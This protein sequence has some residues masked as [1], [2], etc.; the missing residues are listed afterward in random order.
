MKCLHLLSHCLVLSVVLTGGLV[1]GRV[2][3]GDMVSAIADI[4]AVQ[5]GVPFHIGIHFRL[6]PGWY[7]Y[8]R[9]PGDSGLAP[10]IR[11]TAPEGFTV[12]ETLWPLPETINEEGITNYIYKPE[13]LLAVEV[14]PPAV[15]P[16]GVPLVFTAEATWLLCRDLCK[17][18]SATLELILPVAQ[19]DPPESV[20]ADRRKLFADTLKGVPQ[21]NPDLHITASLLG[22]ELLLRFGPGTFVH[23]V[24]AESVRFFPITPLVIDNSGV[25]KTTVSADELL[26]KMPL[27]PFGPDAP[28]PMKGVIEWTQS[29]KTGLERKAF[30]FE[31]APAPGSSPAE[32]VPQSIL[33]HDVPEGVS[34]EPGTRRITTAKAAGPSAFL[35][36]G[37]V[38]KSAEL[39]VAPATTEA[40]ASMGFDMADPLFFIKGATS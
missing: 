28:V 30:Y 32:A 23:G 20:A 27:H 39:Q 29:G 16:P 33:Y 6:E 17:T 37:S 2:N 31:A 18:G 11:W 25:R 12:G 19:A 4:T 26:V 40:F 14:I 36:R 13:V 7:M 22:R 35:S 9:N 3:P 8:W 5:P 24:Q 15:L 38:M 21:T 10:D 34:G 1:N